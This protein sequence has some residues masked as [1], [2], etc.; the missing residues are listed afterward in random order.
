MNKH[1]NVR[2]GKRLKKVREVSGLKK[3][4]VAQ[5]MGL[6]HYQTLS[7]IENGVRAIKVWELAKLCDI[8]CKESKYFMQEEEPVERDLSFAWREK[9]NRKDSKPVESRLKY[10][11]ESYDLLEELTGEKA[12]TN[13]DS[14]NERI[15]ELIDDRVA[16][17]AEN[18]I[19]DLELGRRPAVELSNVMEN[20]LNIK[21]IYVDLE[22]FG[23]AVASYDDERFAIFIN[24]GD[25][26]WRRNFNLA[27]EL[28]HLYSRN[29]F[30]LENLMKYE[31]D[32]QSEIEKIAN[33]FA[34]FLLLPE[35][36]VEEIWN[37]I[38]SKENPAL[39][40][41]IR[42]A[43]NI[44]VSTQALLIR[45]VKLKLL[46]SSK[47]DKVLNS[48]EFKEINKQERSGKNIPAP[49]FSSRF[50]WLGIKALKYGKISKGKFCKIFN[51]NRAEFS[52]FIS[53]RGYSEELIY[54]ENIELNNP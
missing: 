29:I 34:S 39:V 30:P 43:I 54:G 37:G 1:I 31:H 8:Y 7:D 24:A 21:L 20:K 46:E 47:V 17:K 48:P 36:L 11:H 2:V 33:T 40:D 42:A 25:A 9:D 28:F 38:K 3:V 22:G 5:R 10:L 45:M 26:P 13:I 19:A 4:E 15:S 6:N 35:K 51:I 52:R 50:V 16:E 49:M 23:S 32:E 27:H 12:I 14:W 53:E 44:E 41:F 18:L